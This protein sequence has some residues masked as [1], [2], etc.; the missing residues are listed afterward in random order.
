MNSFEGGK[1]V[2]SAF[3]PVSFLQNQHLQTLWPVFFRKPPKI[4]TSRERI[5]TTDRDFIDLD[6]FEIPDRPLIILLHGL[7]SSSK[8]K[9]IRGLQKSLAKHG[10]ASVAMNLRGC[11]GEPN[12]KV[13]G[14]HAGVS[15]DL[16][17]VVETLR[18]RFSDRPLGAIGY[19]LGANILL[20][21]LSE[22]QEDATL[23]AGISVSA[24]LQLD[25]TTD[26][27][28]K[29]FSKIYEQYLLSFMKWHQYQKNIKLYQWEHI[30]EI[31]EMLKKVPPLWKI[32]TISDFDELI[33]A[34]LHGFQDAKHYYQT[35]S[36]R[37]MLKQIRTPTL[38]IHAKDDPFMPPEVLPHENELS[39]SVMVE[40]SDKGGHAG[41]VTF[42]RLR[43][44]SYWIDMRAPQFF[45]QI[46]SGI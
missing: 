10:F 33:T 34:P 7:A 13:E 18:K 15:D 31:R 21:W 12:N 28:Q 8:A 22:K 43:L 39:N 45:Q 26:R 19:S 20:K 41:F 14:Y 36:S 17:L 42:N 40:V 44:P 38:I 30:P 11:S 2:E 23:F 16:E 29:G 24:P 6:W 9:Y 5:L 4:K 46:L 37:F 27:L 1:I 35:C 3:E 25:L 32:D